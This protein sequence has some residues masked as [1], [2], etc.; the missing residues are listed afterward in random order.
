MSE[1]RTEYDLQGGERG[2]YYRVYWQHPLPTFVVRVLPDAIA[3]GVIKKLT[4]VLRAYVNDVRRDEREACAILA[5][6]TEIVLSDEPLRPR[7]TVMGTQVA[8]AI[9][10]RGEKEQGDNGQR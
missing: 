8:A 4:A 1:M 3:D 2:R 6:A 10:A 9:R 7:I 5:E